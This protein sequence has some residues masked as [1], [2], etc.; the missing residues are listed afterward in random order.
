MCV[1]FLLQTQ[2][3]LGCSELDAIFS[4]IN[5]HPIHRTDFPLLQM[6]DS[7]KKRDI[8]QDM[9]L[10]RLKASEPRRGPWFWRGDQCRFGGSQGQAWPLLRRGGC[11]GSTRGRLPSA[12]VGVAAFFPFRV[13]LE[14]T[15]MW[16]QPDGREPSCSPFS[17]PSPATECLMWVVLKMND[18]A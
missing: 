7:R 9:R 15:G 2:T 5:T 8:L 18:S 4:K 11:S 14:Y 1:M 10:T 12:A 16:L 3:S 17:R 13:F 6:Q